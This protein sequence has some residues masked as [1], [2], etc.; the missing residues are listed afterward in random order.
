[1]PTLEATLLL[2]QDG[3]DVPGFPVT[4]RLFVVTTESDN[5]GT[6]PPD[7]AFH[8]FGGLAPT[9]NVSFIQTLDQA[10]TVRL[11]GQSDAG[12]VLNAGGLLLVFGGT[13]NFGTAGNLTVKN[14]SGITTAIQVLVGGGV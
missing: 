5:D 3:V 4:R 1:M 12:I 9:Q 13:L 6:L 7:A 8:P 14:A 2:K 11:N 10:V